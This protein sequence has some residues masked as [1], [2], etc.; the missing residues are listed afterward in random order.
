MPCCGKRSDDDEQRGEQ[1]ARRQRRRSLSSY[2]D[3]TFLPYC[4]LLPAT[5]PPC[6]ASHLQHPRNS[7]RLLPFAL[8]GSAPSALLLGVG[9]LTTGSRTAWIHALLN[10]AAPPNVLP[11]LFRPT[12]NCLRDRSTFA[13]AQK[14]ERLRSGDMREGG[15]DAQVAVHGE[16]QE[17]ALATFRFLTFC[18]APTS[19]RSL[20]AFLCASQQHGILLER[21]GAQYSH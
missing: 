14:A 8:L 12:F 3:S 10:C 7:I 21:Q 2:Y 13:T 19:R 1:G 4:T 6:T 5:R 16:G 17:R 20:L 15:N 9:S 18:S 11:A